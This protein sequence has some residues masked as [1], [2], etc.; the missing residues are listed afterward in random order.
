MNAALLKGHLKSNGMTYKQIAERLGMTRDTFARRL[1]AE[2]FTVE[3]A[4]I[5]KDVLSLSPQETLA[6]FFDM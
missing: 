4:R 5:I 2:T 6:V 1:G 3:D